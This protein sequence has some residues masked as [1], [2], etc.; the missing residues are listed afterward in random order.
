MRLACSCHLSPARAG[1]LAFAEGRNY[2]GVVAVYTIVTMR[3]LSWLVVKVYLLR[4]RRGRF[5]RLTSIVTLL[6][7]GLWSFGARAEGRARHFVLMAWDGM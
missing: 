6:G 3:C 5:F 1:Q 7:V 4:I 2:Q